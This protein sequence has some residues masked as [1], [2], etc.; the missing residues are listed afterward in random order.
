MAKYKF[1]GQFQ[2]AAGKQAQNLLSFC[3]VWK[4]IALRCL[5][6]FFCLDPNSF[7]WYDYPGLF[8]KVACD[9]DGLYLSEYFDS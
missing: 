9:F 3:I 6:A 1:L 8:N 2:G 7:C 5:T 4:L